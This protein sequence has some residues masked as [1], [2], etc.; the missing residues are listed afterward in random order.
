MASSIDKNPHNTLAQHESAQT[1][2]P[3]KAPARPAPGAKAAAPAAP[4]ESFTAAREPGAAKAA[5]SQPLLGA[6][7]KAPPK[8]APQAK[9]QGPGSLLEQQSVLSAANN[10]LNKTGSTS[11]LVKKAAGGLGVSALG[12]SLAA[13][14]LAIPA[15]IGAVAVASGA[16]LL[17]RRSARQTIRQDSDLQ[18]D[19]D[20]LKAAVDRISKLE[21]PS[22]VEKATL[23]AAQKGLAGVKG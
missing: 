21:N 13:P 11:G 15:A 5:V 9:T 3:A 2:T 16:G 22:Q 18:G 17:A 20:V 4:Q 12:V 23:N 19:V 6:F 1:H 10:L 14:F 7:A 8:L